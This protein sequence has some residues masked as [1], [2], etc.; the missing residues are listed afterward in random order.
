ML[1]PRP[2]LRALLVILSSSLAA[3]GCKDRGRELTIEQY[4]EREVPGVAGFTVHVSDISAGSVALITIKRA[5][6]GAV[7]AKGNLHRDDE[8]PFVVRENGA[9]VLTVDAY[10]D[11]IIGDEAELRIEDRRP[12][13]KQ[14][15]LLPIGTMTMPSNPDIKLTLEQLEPPRVRVGVTTPTSNAEP[16]W[17]TLGESVEFELRAEPYELQPVSFDGA[18]VYVIVAPRR[19]PRR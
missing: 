15:A 17:Y 12:K 16:R 5:A 4:E 3:A 19:R 14:V 2:L 1:A 9:H 8:M 18:A 7:I 13:S 10:H 11:H 6:D